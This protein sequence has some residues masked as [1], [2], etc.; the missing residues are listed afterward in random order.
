MMDEK[1]TSVDVDE[2]MIVDENEIVKMVILEVDRIVGV[3]YWGVCIHTM[4][5]RITI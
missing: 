4:I 5:R 1:A 3:V 2:T